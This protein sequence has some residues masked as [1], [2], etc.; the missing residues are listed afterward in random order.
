M[1]PSNE[2]CDTDMGL[3][4]EHELST[5]ENP[6]QNSVENIS[7]GPL[8][9]QDSPSGNEF[10]HLDGGETHRQD[11][12]FVE[13]ID[14][15]DTKGH[16]LRLNDPAFRVFGKDEHIPSEEFWGHIIHGASVSEGETPKED[17]EAFLKE[18]SHIRSPDGFEDEAAIQQKADAQR[19]AGRQVS[20][21]V[22]LLP[23]YNTRVRE[24]N[25]HPNAPNGQYSADQLAVSRLRQYGSD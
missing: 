14:V 8:K 10:A 25:K 12:N 11:G 21:E 2:F 3:V 22:L 4:D 1:V 23:Q 15:G 7:E 19:R 9:G 6:K 18:G 17:C 24:D 13:S 16:H 5:I 20:A